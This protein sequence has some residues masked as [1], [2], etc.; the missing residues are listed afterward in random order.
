M[1]ENIGKLRFRLTLLKQ[2]DTAA[3]KTTSLIVKNYEPIATV[4]GDVRPFKGS[5]Y[6]KSKNTDEAMTDEIVIRYNAAY[7][8]RSKITHVYHELESVVFEVDESMTKRHRNRF[9]ILR[10]I[11]RGDS[12]KFPMNA[13]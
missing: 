12:S 4:W 9:L 11:D 1:P 5:H 10:C 8:R 13:P 3:G 6:F 2:A 7:D